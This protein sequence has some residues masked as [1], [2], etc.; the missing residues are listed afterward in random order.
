MHRIFWLAGLVPPLLIAVASSGSPAS[1]ADLQWMAGCWEYRG[2]E[3][4]IE[5]Q[6]M[7]PMGQVMLGTSRT[8]ASGRTIAYEQMIIVEDSIGAVFRSI[9]SGQEPAEFVALELSDSLASFS[10]PDH[11][12]PQFVE[13]RPGAAGDSLWARISGEIAGVAREVHFRYGRIACT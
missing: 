2:G 10:N 8:T 11:D 7:R 4:T 1:I 9:P 3:R 12:F 13:Y 6:W 5:E